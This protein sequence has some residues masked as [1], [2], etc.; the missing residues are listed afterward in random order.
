MSVFM[1]KIKD[2]I[3]ARLKGEHGGF[4]KFAGI[5]TAIVIVILL[6]AP[7]NNF[8]HWTQARIEI[9]RQQKLI[10]F[11]EMEIEAMNDSIRLLRSNKDSL[12]KY[13]RETFHFAAPGDDVYLVED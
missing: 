4:W 12:E 3:N 7:G 2:F 5:S 13:A 8:I 6:I 1:G 11:Y 10:D 9:S